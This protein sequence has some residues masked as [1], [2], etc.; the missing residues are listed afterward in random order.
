MISAEEHQETMIEMR[1]L[2]DT[3]N[4]KYQTCQYL[5]LLMFKV[6]SRTWCKI[7]YF[8]SLLYV[9]YIRALLIWDVYFCRLFVSLSITGD[10][11][12]FLKLEWQ[13]V[14]FTFSFYLF[15]SGNFNVLITKC[16]SSMLEEFWNFFLYKWTWCQIYFSSSD[17]FVM[18]FTVFGRLILFAFNLQCFIFVEKSKK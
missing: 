15:M 13:H 12:P 7:Y 5:V 4:K 3:L 6:F 14:Y 16:Q 17:D 2:I 1:R 9:C 10:I 18:I 8:T 11:E